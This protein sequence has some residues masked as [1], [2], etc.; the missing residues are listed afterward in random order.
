MRCWFSA[1]GRL[2]TGSV[3]LLPDRVY[4]CPTADKATDTNIEGLSFLRHLQAKNR[5]DE[6]TRTADLSSLRVIIH[7]LQGFTQACKSPISKPLSLLCFA[8]VAPYC[9]PGVRVVSG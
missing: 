3:R 6:R 2:I 8:Q 9:V 5:A 1:F 4:C 7:V